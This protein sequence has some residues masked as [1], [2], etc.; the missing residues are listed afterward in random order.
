MA[1]R[2]R[3]PLS[4]TV[5]LGSRE[6]EQAIADYAEE[7]HLEIEE[8]SIENVKRAGTECLALVKANSRRQTGGYVEGFAVD[9]KLTQS[10]ITATVHNKTKPGLT[11][12]LEKGHDVVVNGKRVGRASGDG[13]LKASA[14]AVGGILYEGYD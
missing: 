3:I 1:R 6:F 9:V 14:D 7:L 5:R 8:Q 10:E 2:G 11:H 4:R 13:V 12:L